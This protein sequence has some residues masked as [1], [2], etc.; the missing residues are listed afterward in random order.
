MKNILAEGIVG[1]RPPFMLDQKMA[2]LWVLR[3][4]KRQDQ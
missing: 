1:N 4:F 2:L 3:L